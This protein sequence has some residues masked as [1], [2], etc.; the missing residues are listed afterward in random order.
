M[1]GGEIGVR[2]GDCA[3]G[4]VWHDGWDYMSP[5][6]SELLCCSG[7]ERVSR[8]EYNNMEFLNSS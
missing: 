7:W 4:V 2:A 3:V 8:I 1:R 6:Y 5:E